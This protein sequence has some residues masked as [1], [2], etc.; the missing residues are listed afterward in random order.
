M[1]LSPTISALS[2]TT[3]GDASRVQPATGGRS[4]GFDMSAIDKNVRPGD[5]FFLYANGNY[6]RNLTIPA[7][8]TSTGLL[9]IMDDQ[10]RSEVAPTNG[11]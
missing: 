5:N 7:D 8:K 4:W 6:I 2:Q 11:S 1:T 10:R 3:D 9:G